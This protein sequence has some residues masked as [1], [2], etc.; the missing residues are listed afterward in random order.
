MSIM[1][2]DISNI[3]A[4]GCLPVGSGEGDRYLVVAGRGSP[5]NLTLRCRANTT[6]SLA[7]YLPYGRGYTVYLYMYVVPGLESWM[8]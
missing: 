3:S 6:S 7:H 2:Q 5:T 4:L 8:Q 1:E